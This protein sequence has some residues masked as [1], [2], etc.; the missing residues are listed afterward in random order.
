MTEVMSRVRF[1]LLRA[2]QKDRL[3]AL[4]AAADNCRHCAHECAC[5][6]WIATHNEGEGASPP[7]FCPNEQFLRA[8]RRAR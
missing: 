6:R 5:D 3:E 2:L 8:G 1:N 7:E 4:D